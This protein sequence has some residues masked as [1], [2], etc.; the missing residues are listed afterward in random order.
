MHNSLNN[1]SLNISQSDN[2]Q[3]PKCYESSSLE[4]SIIKFNRNNPAEFDRIICKKC[5]FEFCYI[6]C[7]FCQKKIYMRMHIECP[8]Y[9]GMNAF[10]IYCPYK[11][12]EKVFYFTECIKCKRTQKQKNISKK[13]NASNVY[14]MTANL[15]TFRTIAQCF[16]ALIL[17]QSKKIKCLPISHK[18]F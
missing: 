9:N 2:I 8:K 10:N 11:L 15:F 1:N 7:V 16:I 6:V 13:E 3:C 5:S 17:T 12:C 18:G 14:M 4:N